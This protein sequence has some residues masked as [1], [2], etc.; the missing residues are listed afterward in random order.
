M[1]KPT[2]LVTG[3]AGFIGS[4][5]VDVAL[6]EGYAV[7]VVDSLIGGHERNLAH[8]GHNQ[9]LSFEKADIRD[10]DADAAIFICWDW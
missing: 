4:H 7:R 8:H 6:S 1:T 5:L 9:D 2:L 10:L 3:G